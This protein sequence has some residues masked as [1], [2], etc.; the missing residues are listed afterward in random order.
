[1]LGLK[2][3]VKTGRK[4]FRRGDEDGKSRGRGQGG[5]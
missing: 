2:I 5:A 4:E 3:E 1:M